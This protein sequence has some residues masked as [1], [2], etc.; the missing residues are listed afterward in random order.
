LK[1]NYYDYAELESM[2]GLTLQQ[3]EKK[4]ERKIDSFGSN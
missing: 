3:E 2:L 1:G 4:E